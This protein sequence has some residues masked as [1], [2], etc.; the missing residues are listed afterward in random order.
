MPSPNGRTRPA[1]CAACGAPTDS[2][3][4][5]ISGASGTGSTG[6]SGS[7]SCGSFAHAQ[8]AREPE[9][10]H[11]AS[12][13]YL[14]EGQIDRSIAHAVRSHELDRAKELILANWIRFIVHWRVGPVA[15][16]LD[17]LPETV[18]QGDR[19]LAYVA[20]AVA[21]I[22]GNGGRFSECLAVLKSGS[23]AGTDD[24]PPPETLSGF[25][26]F[27]GVEAMRDAAAEAVELLSKR[28]D[29]F[30][31]WNAQAAYGRALFLGGD[32][33]AARPVLEQAV[34]ELTL[35]RFPVLYVYAMAL[36]GARVGLSAA[37]MIRRGAWQNAPRRQ[38][39]PHASATSPTWG[40]S[41]SCADG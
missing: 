18:I 14:Q 1:S 11:R 6:C 15:G 10:H 21:L 23:E 32:A 20:A 39:N 26:W 34:G 2:R 5:S 25:A 7:C 4:G 9:L 36:G 33:V 35:T 19:R 38:S 3:W 22:D 37:C 28:P 24:Q 17:L 12:E 13:W 41:R 29:S 40:S 27:Y 8:P 16:W 30:W 31:L